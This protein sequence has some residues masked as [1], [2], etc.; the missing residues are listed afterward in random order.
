MCQFPK[1]RLFTTIAV[2]LLSI[3]FLT[4]RA[5]SQTTASLLA[6]KGNT[7][8][9]LEHAT[10]VGHSD[11][12]RVL[13]IVVS[14]KLRNEQELDALIETQS[15]PRSP[16][17][18]QFI[19]AGEFTRRFGPLQ[20]DVEAVAKHLRSQ[21][22]TVHEI[23]PNHTLVVASGSAATVERAFEV[24]IND[25]EFNGRIHFSND[26][27]PNVPAHLHGAIQS[28][29]GLTSFD[30]PR[31]N[32]TAG[33]QSSP[34][35]SYTPPQIAT[36]YNFPNQNNAY[37]PRRNYSGRGVTL[38]IGTFFNF[39]PSDVEFFWQYFGIN[40]S[41]TLTYIPVNGGSNVINNET[42]IDV[43]QSGAQA[44]GANLLVYAGPSPDHANFSLMLSR[45]TTDNIASVVT[46][47]WDYCEAV[48]PFNNLA[49]DHQT[50]KQG[51]AQGISYFIAAADAGAFAC[52]PLS[53]N[54]AVAYPA[55]DPFVSAVGG[56][57]LKVQSNGTYGSETAWADSG[58]ADSSIF[59]RPW[60]QFGL[61]VPPTSMRKIS[62]VAFDADPNTGYWFYF[63]G[64]WYS[65]QGGTSLGAPNWAALWTVG[66]E[67][68]GGR[69]T[70]NAAPLI[71]LVG[72]TPLYQTVFHD[73]TTGSNG[74]V[75]FVGCIG[76]GFSA[77][78]FWDYPTGWGTPNGKSVVDLLRAVFG[79]D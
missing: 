75:I 78:P 65:N 58:G 16:L 5:N 53:S 18:H 57:T 24:E 9:A 8:A 39:E 46:V 55:S 70:G 38:A 51:A 77:G 44:P 63:Q 73:V 68:D 29:I 79:E 47:S 17:Y 15:D 25:Y 19:D 37:P 40:R 72:N 54:P 20:S 69:R 10:L 28:V 7:S 12:N 35:F 33:T 11:P 22:L 3:T 30:A 49:T 59:P 6:V 66:I 21:G 45:L 43:E 27:D 52:Y 23:A 71:Y 50:L 13:N 41:G 2:A 61:G 1:A 34:L 36:A 48:V 64:N 42:S 31:R 60:W 62:D 4:G 76:P 56:T 67:A 14:L 74:C 26:R 32:S